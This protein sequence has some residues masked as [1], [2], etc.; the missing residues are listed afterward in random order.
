[1]LAEHCTHHDLAWDAGCGNGQL[2]T[3]L[4]R[5]FFKVIGSD[6][7]PEQL[8]QAEQA[9]T[10]SYLLSTAD[11]RMLD[12]RSVDLAVSAQAAHWFHWTY[13]VAEVERVTKPG[14]IVATVSYGIM[15]VPGEAG[16]LLDRYY[17]ETVGKFWPP[18]RR[19]VENG[20]RDLVWPWPE[21]PTPPVDMTAEWTRDELI[22][23]VS[24]WSATVRMIE[25]LGPAPYE[26]LTRDLAAVWPD[27]ERRTIRWPLA[28]RLA[29]RS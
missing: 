12:A 17:R 21:I 20:Y 4:T 6:P 5:R 7:S 9:A 29:H 27:G 15:A 10:V 13:Y 19:H 23:Y 3:M 8:A 16:A 25:V 18:E 22:G 26:Q 11:Q 14:A 28:I 2:T 1:M 24:T